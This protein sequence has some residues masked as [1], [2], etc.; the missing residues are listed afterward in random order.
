VLLARRDDF[1]GRSS[2]LGGT[3]PYRQSVAMLH[4]KSGDRCRIRAE[5]RYNQSSVRLGRKGIKAASDVHR[6]VAEAVRYTLRPQAKKSR[7]LFD[8]RR[9]SL[10]AAGQ[11]RAMVLPGSKNCATTPMC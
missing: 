10:Q 6:R 1:G 11:T 3:D 9:S 7:S 5:L 8:P 4:R 2:S